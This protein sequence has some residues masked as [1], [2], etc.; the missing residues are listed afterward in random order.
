MGANDCAARRKGEYVAG[1]IAVVPVAAHTRT[2]R[3]QVAVRAPS[4]RLFEAPGLEAASRHGYNLARVRLNPRCRRRRSSFM[5]PCPGRG[6]PGHISGA[7]FM[8]D[9]EA[10]HRFVSALPRAGARW[11]ES[12]TVSTIDILLVFREPSVFFFGPLPVCVRPLGTSGPTCDVARGVVTRALDAPI[13]CVVIG[14]GIRRLCSDV[15]RL[16]RR[17]S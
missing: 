5:R 6:D 4:A 1:L 8:S 15:R 17:R 13:S 14:S 2:A 9:S 3:L 16:S 7:A 12:M 10:A 11:C